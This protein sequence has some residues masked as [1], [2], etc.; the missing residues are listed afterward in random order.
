MLRKIALT[1]I[2]L[3]ILG[4]IAYSFMPQPVV[5]EIGPVERRV[6]REYVSEEAKTRLADE[7]TLD[8]PVN[9]TLERIKLEIGDLVKAGEVIAHVDAFELEQRIAGVESLIAQTDAYIL[10]IDVQKPK[11]E[12][13]ASADV[14]VQENED[15]ISIAERARDVAAIEMDDARREFKRAEE[16]VV[17]GVGSQQL[18]DQAERRYRSAQQQ[19]TSATVAIDAARKGLELA[20]LASRRVIG[21]VDDNEYMREAYRA[22]KRNLEAQLRIYRSDLE[23]TEILAPVSGPVLEKYLEDRR[24]LA[25]GTPVLK[26][27]D[28]S[29]MEIES[30]ILSEEIVNVD[31]GDTV[32]IEGKAV[33]SEAISSTVSRIY[34]S[35]FTK[36]SSLGIEQQ[37]VKTIINFDPGTLVLRPGTRLDIRIITDES[38][39][40]IAVPERATFRR[41]GQ[42]YVFVVEGGNAQLRP[43]RIGLKNDTW[44]EVVEGLSE[45]DQIVYEP[46]N[47]IMD[48][49]RL[50]AR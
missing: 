25:A 6:V 32:E 26:I 7:Y 46:N 12:D 11:E 49:S 38:A 42:W 9:G 15:R 48:G 10:G 22:E 36:I 37:R 31:E 43:I 41:D 20:S 24:V 4:G 29:S 3:V 50:E 13:L 35:A 23:K 34:P 1:I 21:S 5:V 27:G 19:M 47:E 30:D 44:A 33:S 28:L 14:R 40:V 45:T 16:L 39:N 8:M 17:Q 2:A 18:L